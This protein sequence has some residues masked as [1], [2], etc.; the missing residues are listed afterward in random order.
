M[1][2]YLITNNINN[3]KYVGI[4]KDIKERFNYH[5]TRYNR[6]KEWNKPLYKAFRKYGIDNFSFEILNDNLTVEEAKLKEIE[7][8]KCYKSLSHQSGYNISAGGDLPKYWGEDVNT[9]KLTEEQVK[10]IIGRRDSGELQKD[11]FNDYNNIVGYSAFQHIWLGKHWK[12]LQKDYNKFQR[13]KGASSL[14][15]NKVIAIKKDL[16]E[17]L[18][19]PDTARKNEVSYKKVYNISKG[20]TYLYITV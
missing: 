12:H 1:Y 3:K 6:K 14:S 19:V 9:S 16:L 10:D 8:I 5:K 7:Y 2:V 17:G 18:S 15:V 13:T 20:T 11:V 4:T